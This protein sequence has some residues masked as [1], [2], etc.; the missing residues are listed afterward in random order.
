MSLTVKYY[1]TE[2]LKFSYNNNLEITFAILDNFDN[3]NGGKIF[4][5]KHNEKGQL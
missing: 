1:E 5:R 2:S 4:V 3:Q